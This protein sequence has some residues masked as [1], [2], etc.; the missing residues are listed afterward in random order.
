MEQDKKPNSAPDSQAIFDL[1]AD[2]LAELDERNDVSDGESRLSIQEFD[3]SAFISLPFFDKDLHIEKQPFEVNPLSPT[4]LD[5]FNFVANG[6]YYFNSAE[7]LMHDRFNEKAN[8]TNISDEARA[9]IGREIT[10]QHMMQSTKNAESY[11]RL[12]SAVALNPSRLDDGMKSAIPALRSGLASSELRLRLLNQFPEMIAIEDMKYTC[13]LDV[14][15]YQKAISAYVHQF[16]KLQ[17]TAGVNFFILPKDERRARAI[18]VSESADSNIVVTK[19]CLAEVFYED[20]AF[21]LIER[22]SFYSFPTDPQL[23][24]VPENIVRFIDAEATN[25]Q[26]IA[27][28]VYM[29]HKKL[30][31]EESHAN[32]MYFINDA[33][34]S[35]LVKPKTV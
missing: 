5:P 12:R 3:E 1:K 35:I 16:T 21:E 25:L 32:S 31:T 26:P 11:K 28:S 6:E 17:F 13:A 15:A 10:T 29:R 7:I 34:K 24:G 23:Q 9:A 2:L 27:V 22:R 33:M 30:Q 14:E 19:S 20:T 4:P 8:Q 18:D